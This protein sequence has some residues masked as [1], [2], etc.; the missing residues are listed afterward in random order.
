MSCEDTVYGVRTTPTPAP[1]STV[2]STWIRSASNRRRKTSKTPGP[3]TS[4]RR[5]RD[6]SG[7]ETDAEYGFMYN[8]QQAVAFRWLNLLYQARGSL[9]NEDLTEATHR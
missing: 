5:S 4:S 2:L 9:T 1:S 7:K 3:G 8:F 6:A